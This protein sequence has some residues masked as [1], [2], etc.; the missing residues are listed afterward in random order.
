MKINSDCRIHVGPTCRFHLK[1]ALKYF[2]VNSGKNADIYKT[3]IMKY[4]C[5]E[6]Q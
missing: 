4:T 3:S 5:V 6:C 2:F 1:Y